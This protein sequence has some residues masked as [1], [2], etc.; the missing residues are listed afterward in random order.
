MIAEQARSIAEGA[1]RRHS[2]PDQAEVASVDRLYIET[3]QTGPE[4]PS[5]VRDVLVW[6]VNFGFDDGARWVELAVDD[7]TGEIVR[8]RRS[9]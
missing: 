2:V 7:R 5:P 6:A 1:R 3:A 8:V 4:A 9:R